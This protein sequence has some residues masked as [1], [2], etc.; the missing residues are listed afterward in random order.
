[1]S[2]DLQSENTEMK[3]KLEFALLL[4]VFAFCP[5]NLGA[6]DS[7]E[8]LIGNLA[9]PDV[10]VQQRAVDLLRKQDKPEAQERAV[11]ALLNLLRIRPQKKE[12]LRLRKKTINA[13]AKIGRGNPDVVRAIF[14]ESRER[15]RFAA[16]EAAWVAELDV[17]GPGNVSVLREFLSSGSPSQQMELLTFIAARTSHPTEAEKE[18]LGHLLENPTA[19]IEFTRSF[20]EAAEAWKAELGSLVPAL[21]SAILFMLDAPK[22]EGME[23][24]DIVRGLFGNQSD[25]RAE[26]IAQLSRALA[27][28]A[29]GAETVR[30]LSQEVR[31]AMQA[32]GL[33]QASLAMLAR[34][35]SIAKE[36][37][38]ILHP[39]MDAW[40]WID[41]L[42][43]RLRAEH[44]RG[45][46]TSDFSAKALAISEKLKLLS[47]Q[48]KADFFSELA[49]D[50]RKF[51]RAALFLVF[52]VKHI[53][54]SK[55]EETLQALILDPY[56]KKMLA[57][58][59]KPKR[60]PGE[61]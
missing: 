23:L 58:L 26:K 27:F 25:S 22:T 4:S 42:L 30:F 8:T 17:I 45:L 2:V 55:H 48:E 35:I 13:L 39:Q 3:A 40:Q 10:E 50:A 29:P 38:E 19:D 36:G 46:G 51:N 1:M 59:R 28:I 54:L 41:G 44:Y 11:K 34:P 32:A 20:A 60:R 18:L 5:T 16:S 43:K 9:S 21:R 15:G 52:L 56:C 12:F 61:S 24:Q 53:D 31:P 37:K 47:A 33:N 57:E 7:L 6:A 14:Q 49:V